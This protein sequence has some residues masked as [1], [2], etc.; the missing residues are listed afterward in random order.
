MRTGFGQKQLVTR[1]HRR[2][3]VTRRFVTQLHFFPRDTGN[4]PATGVNGTTGLLAAA[5]EGMG[6]STGVAGTS[7]PCEFR[8]CDDCAAFSCALAGAIACALP[9]RP[10]PFPPDEAPTCSVSH[11]AKTEKMSARNIPRLGRC[12]GVSF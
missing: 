4:I 2:V 10:F 7:S 12:F 11:E 6:S 1:T 5:G 3:C 8:A 9:T